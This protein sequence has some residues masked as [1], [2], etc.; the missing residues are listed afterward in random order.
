MSTIPDDQTDL[1]QF[2]SDLLKA[3]LQTHQ[4]K[5]LLSYL[6]SLSPSEPCEIAALLHI[7]VEFH[8]NHIAV[9]DSDSIIS[10]FLPLLSPPP[11]TRPHC[12][13][14]AAFVKFFI[15][16]LPYLQDPSPASAVFECLFVHTLFEYP[17]AEHERLAGRLLELIRVARF[18]E[19][20]SVDPSFILALLSSPDLQQVVISARLFL[21]LPPDSRMVV[22]PQALDIFTTLLSSS[23]DPRPL[24]RYM[25]QFLSITISIAPMAGLLPLVRGDDELC[26]EFVR[27]LAK[28]DPAIA[29]ALFADAARQ[30]P[31]IE[32][33]SAVMSVIS[34]FRPVLPP[35]FCGELCLAYA[36][37]LSASLGAL[38]WAEQSEEGRQGRAFVR[39]LF[40]LAGCVPEPEFARQMAGLG[41]RLIVEAPHEAVIIAVAEFVGGVPDEVAVEIAGQWAGLIG[42]VGEKGD[43]RVW[44]RVVA[45]GRRLWIA[46]REGFEEGLLAALGGSREMAGAYVQMMQSGEVDDAPMMVFAR[47]MREALDG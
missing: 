40:A 11:L 23:P 44:R 5:S 9:G 22:L 20:V 15:R 25:I 4:D 35:V 19:T 24:L 2:S 42:A 34:K 27:S 14:L 43:V 17:E 21:I 39:G 13:A 26:A 36:G 18:A 10:N 7:L 47:L 31:G 46:N 30:P 33:A 29:S 38:D 45:M 32:T 8:E 3:A 37:V 1:D 41:L 6:A 16:N 12:I 28:F